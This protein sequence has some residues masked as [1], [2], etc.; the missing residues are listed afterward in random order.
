[1][2]KVRRHGGIGQR[3]NRLENNPVGAH[4]GGGAKGEHDAHVQRVKDQLKDD[5]LPERV[6]EPLRAGI[7]MAIESIAK[8]STRRASYL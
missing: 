8:S 4:A 5:V 6:F 7:R 3:S 2:R 1:M